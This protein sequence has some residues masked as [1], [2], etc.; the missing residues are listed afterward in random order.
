MSALDALLGPSPFSSAT[1]NSP[2]TLLFDGG[3]KLHLEEDESLENI[4][5]FSSPGILETREWLA[6]RTT[7]WTSNMEHPRYAGVVSTLAID[8]DSGRV[9]IG[10]AWPRAAFDSA[11][12]AGLLE[13]HLA[14][15]HG[16]QKAL[17]PTELRA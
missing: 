5:V 11:G 12:L 1:P 14:R 10:D 9:Y 4:V 17:A 6:G 13:D 7:P 16:W 15:H 3:E 2:R 8:P